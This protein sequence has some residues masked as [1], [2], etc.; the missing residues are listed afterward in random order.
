MNSSN[1]K[2]K[3]LSLTV[4]V[5]SLLSTGCSPAE[6]EKQDGLVETAR[7]SP[8]I[9]RSETKFQFSR[10]GASPFI[11]RTPG[12][13]YSRL[14][15][16]PDVLEFKDN[17]YYFFRGQGESGH[18]EIGVWTKPASDADGFNWN[19]TFSDPV[20]PVS[21]DKNAPD[22]DYILDPAAIVFKD[23]IFVYYTAKSLKKQP[24]YSIALAISSDG[25][26]FEKFSGNPVL[27]GVIAPEIIAYEG[28]L[29][30]FYQR[31]NLVEDYWEVFSR[32][33]TNGIDFDP[34]SE[35]RVFG[36]TRG[37]EGFDSYSVTTV[38]IFEENGY[39]YMTYGGC[40]KFL[41]YPESIGLARSK[42][43]S[44]WERY[45]GNPIFSRGRAGEWDEGAL[46]YATVHKFNGQ[47]LMWY[48][49]AGSGMG[50]STE[51]AR[52]ASW[53]A[54]E[55]NYGGYLE[56]SFSQ[57]GVAIATGSLSDW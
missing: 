51:E 21:L 16:N 40:R 39:F 36:P 52:R 30:L 1:L 14:V 46:W 38:R 22:T 54:R 50:L 8:P 18:D 6:L 2:T 5:E 44:H 3:L 26:K 7:Y 20:I 35:R 42:D 24:N 55:E 37:T 45:P 28:Q 41:D 4:T 34:A 27:E 23:S 15:A 33:S 10:I 13:F 53:L 12:T 57:I 29:H 48:E 49:G 43:L 47:Y 11:S 31:H 25:K 17:F 19:K 9:E 56:T 32:T